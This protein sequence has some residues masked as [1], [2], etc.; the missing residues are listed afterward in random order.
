MQPDADLLALEKNF[1]LGGASFYEDHLSADATMLFPAG[2]MRREEIIASIA[3]GP[4]WQRVRI[5]DPYIAW[6]APAVAVVTYQAAASRPGTPAYES[7]VTSVYVQSANG[8][9]LAFHQQQ[10][11]S[12]L[13]AMRRARPVARLSA[14]AVGA[15]ALGAVATGALAI[16]ALA[17]GRLAIGALA[18]GRARVRALT[19]DELTLRR[20]RLLDPLD[21]ES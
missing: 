8:W 7:H 3:E 6:P 12:S 5:D 19:I 2:L 13:Q 10:P 9:Q 17:V 14:S 1:W 21:S 4:R 15:A 11:R 20:V 16:G 18:L